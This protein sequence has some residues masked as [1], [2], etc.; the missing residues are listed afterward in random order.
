MGNGDVDDIDVNM[1]REGL[2][3]QEQERDRTRKKRKRGRE[4][5]NLRRKKE[6]KTK[7]VNERKVKL[8]EWKNR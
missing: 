8:L 2:N 7:R 3:D 6:K 4:G 1:F 5:E